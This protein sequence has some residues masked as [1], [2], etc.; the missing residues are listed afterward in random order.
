MGCCQSTYEPVPEPLF[1]KGATTWKLALYNAKDLSDEQ[2]KYWVR[3]NYT[4]A[5]KMFEV[6][7]NVG[8]EPTSYMKEL[9]QSMTYWK[10][11]ENSKLNQRHERC[12][13]MIRLIATYAP[14][15]TNRL[16]GDAVMT[17][18]DIPTIEFI[19][20]SPRLEFIDKETLAYAKFTPGLE[21]ISTILEEWNAKHLSL[22]SCHSQNGPKT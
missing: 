7:K 13:A 5:H 11:Y 1:V 15:M 8:R 4:E 9:A 16:L 12:C 17:L 21:R 3:H 22:P 14:Q 20:K 19:L 2:I 18:Q 6:F 10:S